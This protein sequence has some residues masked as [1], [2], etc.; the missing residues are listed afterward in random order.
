M[1]KLNFF[2][3]LSL[4]MVSVWGFAQ[5]V[6]I[7]GNVS[8]DN[9]LAL[10]GATV[11]VE[12]T[13]NGVTTDFDGNYSISASVGDVLVFSY[14]GFD[15]KSTTV[16]N[17]SKINVQLNSSNEL[18]EVVVTGITSRDRKR[19]TSSSVVVSSELIEGIALS[20]PDQALQGRV[21][22]LRVAT[23]SGTPGAPQ[24]I[25]IRGEGSI[26]GSNSPLFVI[27]G[28]PVNNSTISPLL[29]DMGILSMINASDIESITVLK[30]A[31][32]TA[33]YGA[34]GSNGVIVITTKSGTAGE[35][36]YNLTTSYGFQNYALDERRMLNGNERLELGAETLINDYGWDKE[37]ATNYALANFAG[38]AAWDAGGRVDGNWEDLIKV[39]DAP[40]QSYDLSASGGSA[41]ENFRMSVGYKNTVGTSV[42][43][44]FESISGSFTYR[45]KAGKVDIISSNR[46]TNSVQNGIHEGGSYFGAPQANRIFMSPFQQPKNPDGTWN[47]N[48]TT[49]VFNTL[50]LAE[51][52][53]QQNDGTRM[54][55]NTTVNYKFTDDLKFSTRVAL[56]YV[57]GASHEYRNQFHG[58]GAGS[59][60]YSYQSTNRTQTL[61][62]TNTLSYDKTFNDVHFISALAQMEWQKNKSTTNSSSGQGVAAEGLYYVG[63]FGSNQSAYGGLS[64]WKQL[65]YLGL[66]NYS[67]MDK[68][69]ADFSF[70]N[71]GSSR[72]ALGY[73]FGNFWSAGVAWNVTNENFL[74]DNK[75]INN[76]KFRASI[77]ETGSNSVGLNA[78]QSLFGY[79]NSYNDQGA[80]YPSSFGNLLLSWEKQT[81]YDI[82]IDFGLF[83]NRITG[84]VGYYNKNTN[85]LLQSVPLS[86]TSGHSSQTQNVGEVENKGIEIELSADILRLGDF[87]WNVYG[88]YATNDNEVLA[89]AKDAQGNDLNLDGSYNRTRAG[90]GIG[91][92]YI[93]GW[94]GVDSATGDPRY[95]KGGATDPSMEI[96]NSYGA[97]SQAVQGNRIPTYSG[98]IGTRLNFKNFYLDGNF[99]FQG[100]HKI[101]ER[102]S[103]YSEST[104]LLSTRYYQGA[105]KL[106]ERWQKPGDITEVPRM[107]W[108]TSTSGTGSGTTTRFLHD[109][110]FIRL[111]DVVMGYSLP[112]KIA[113][114]LGL[115]NVGFSVRGLNLFTWVKDPD[116]TVD[117]E[118]R[119]T[120]AFEI[121]TPP[122]K[123]ISVGVN[124]KF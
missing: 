63:S 85:D 27:D 111:R 118:T 120:G 106:L 12:G 1:K 94:A 18:E 32:A 41:Q 100:G 66:L 45:R 62:L 78:Y 23:T 58:D 96:V 43:T 90:E 73:R 4:V 49:S 59:G 71:E 9:S 10:P 11:L 68:Y 82:G 5:D 28:V 65:S 109:G 64:D 31:S 6:T 54:I 57:L 56:D 77:G 81:L 112:Q 2:V 83:D 108:S 107:R 69:I 36:K 89:L 30:D 123:S 92:W 119:N 44:D 93:R 3:T 42:G 19:L 70:K 24:E 48:L 7:T 74:S 8:D 86:T 61:A 79:G 102:W 16:G 50:Y 113:N 52:N 105:A 20:S 25:R 101:F 116:L 114:R 26:S 98:G 51:K 15:S 17:S 124:L 87:S 14:V 60:G 110:D 37:R 47:I 80:V 99:Y 72:F 88:N 104:N 34:R 33:P 39:K 35:V 117:P 122:L 21:A 76:L 84:S 55:S 115:D 13:S 29:T 67:Y 53:I 46:V 97:A 103:W 121:F 75:V 95:Y 38:A 40:Y 22:G 91:V